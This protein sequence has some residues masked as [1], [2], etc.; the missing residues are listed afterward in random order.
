M[1]N[2]YAELTQEQKLSIDRRIN[3]LASNVAQTKEQTMLDP[4]DGPYRSCGDNDR[5]GI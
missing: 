5:A 2:R 3:A 1:A 4:V